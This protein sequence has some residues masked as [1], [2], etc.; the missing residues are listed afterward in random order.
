MGCI[1]GVAVFG[2]VA[3]MLALAIVGLVLILIGIAGETDF[4]V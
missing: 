4:V 2:E 1:Q 3:Q